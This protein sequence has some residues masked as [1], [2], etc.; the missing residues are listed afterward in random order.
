MKRH[1]LI[2]AAGLT[3]LAACQ[4]DW[5]EHY[6]QQP[7]SAYGTASIYEIIASR[8]ELSDFR[9]VLDSARL[10]AGNRISSTHY[11]QLLGADQ[12]LTVWAPV[13]GTF[14]RDS[15][16]RMCQTVNG[17]SLVELHFLKNHIARFAH[18]AVEGQSQNVRALN[19]KTIMQVGQRFGNAVISEANIASRNGVLHI[20]SNP[21]T[22]RYN[23]YE[24]LFSLP[25]YQ[26]IGHFLQS[27]QI[28][29]FDET[30]SLAMGVVDGKTVY[31]DSVFYSWNRLLTTHTYGHIDSEDSTYWMLV[32]DRQLWD[33]LYSEADTYFRYAETTPKRDSIHEYWTNYALLQDLSYNPHEQRSMR[34][35]LCSTTWQQYTGGEYHVY[36][37]P[38]SQGGLMSYVGDSLTCSNG[39]IYELNSWPFQKEKTYFRK[40]TA[41]G[42]GKMYDSFE[43]SNK[44]LNMERRFI[45]SDSISGGGYISITP[46]TQYDPYYVVYE[47]PNVLSGCYDVCLVMLPKTVYNP[48]YD[49]TIDKKQ[50]RPNKFV[51]EITYG[52][53][54]GKEYTVSSANR[55]NFDPSDPGYYVK[56]ASNND[57]SVPYLFECDLNPTSSSTRA[58]TNDPYCVDTIRLATMHF[59]TCNYDQ[60][61]VTTRIKIQNNITNKQTNNYNAEMFIDCILFLPH[62]DESG[63]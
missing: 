49:P 25:E 34:D 6:D 54:D 3:A 4:D 14:D 47:M 48:D 28:D 24:A 46:Q 33:E 38:F 12:F 16:L 31:V 2:L 50:F 63:E 43:A 8:P 1:I 13:N 60:Q 29:E 57:E 20:L 52:G 42:E 32:P 62:T 17:D 44:T 19:T 15:L 56:A 59:P 26:H 30:Q 51:A 10:F 61:K 55:Y 58:F 40:L 5:N 18:S 36:Y 37:N 45:T 7:D 22:Y 41:Q 35:S 39:V 27:Y 21:A 23:I 11:S 53:L 9:A